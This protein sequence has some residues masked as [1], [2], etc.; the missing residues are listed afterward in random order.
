MGVQV[1]ISLESLNGLERRPPCS[2]CALPFIVQGGHITRDL[3]P[4]KWAQ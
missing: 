2:V 4:E 3:D 1:Y